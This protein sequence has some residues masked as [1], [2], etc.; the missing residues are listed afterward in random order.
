M[1]LARLDHDVDLDRPRPA[2]PPRSAR[3]SA[4]GRSRRG[5]RG[6]TARARRAAAARPA[7]RR[8]AL[9]HARPACRRGSGARRRARG[10]APTPSRRSTTPAWRTTPVTR[11]RACSRVASQ[12][13]SCP[14]AECPIATTRARSSSAGASCAGS[15]ARWSTAAAT[16]SSVRGKPPPESR[17]RRRYSTLNA[18]QPRAA[19]SAQS[20]RMSLRPYCALQKPPCSTT[21]TG[22]GPSPA[23]SE[24]LAELASAPFHTGGAQAATPSE[25]AASASRVTPS[26][27]CSGVTPE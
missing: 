23:G 10:R 8:V 14:P 2:R 27:I 18:A 1:V 21:A 11:T 5:R 7:R 12:A 19:R 17:P 15:S 13:A 4:A 3:S 26:S 22:Q 24:Q 6:S 9:G 25:R 16:S 20:G